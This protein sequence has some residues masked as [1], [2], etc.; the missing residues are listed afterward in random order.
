MILAP[1]GDFVQVKIGSDFFIDSSFS[2]QFEDRSEIKAYFP[3]TQHNFP[4]ACAE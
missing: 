3:E 1:K 2:L 4:T